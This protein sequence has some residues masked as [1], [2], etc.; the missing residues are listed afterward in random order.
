MNPKKGGEKMTKKTMAATGLFAAISVAGA[1]GILM[2][3]GSTMSRRV[4]KKAS[5]VMEKTGDR[6]EG[7]LHG[8]MKH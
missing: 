7:M 2:S 1:M 4:A 3:G 5:A 6:I 8:K